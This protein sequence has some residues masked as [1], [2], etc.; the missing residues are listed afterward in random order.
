MQSDQ[1]AQKMFETRIAAALMAL[2]PAKVTFVEAESSKVGQRMIPPSLWTRMIAAE[3]V[4]V[5]APLSARGTFLCRAYADLTQNS[6]RLA[7]LIDQLRPYHAADLIAEWHRFAERGAWEALATALI[8]RHYDP[9]YAK[10]A[11]RKEKPLMHLELDDLEE[12]T[13][14]RVADELAAKIT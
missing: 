3:R 11:E 5:A 13:L 6:A 8:A 9:R 7:R 12:T 2:D 1:P 10:S 14:A 4:H